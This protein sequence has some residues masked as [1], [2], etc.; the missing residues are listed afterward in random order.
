[1]FT[2]AEIILRMISK[3]IRQVI[4]KPSRRPGLLVIGDA[5]SDR[6]IWG[7]AKRLSPEAPVP[8]VD[9][10]EETGTPGG[11]ANVVQNLCKLNAT[12]SLCAVV[13]DDP[14]G[15]ELVEQL[16]DENIDTE[17]VITD[18]SRPTTVKTR[19]MAG[20]HQL[21]RLD[22]ESTSYISKEVEEKL[23][24]AVEKKIAAADMVLLSDYNKGL[25]SESFSQKVIALCNKKKKKVAIDPKGLNYEKYTGAWLIKPNK[26][27]LAE[28][29]NLEAIENTDALIAAARKVIAKTKSKYMV[30]TRSEEGLALVSKNTFN[31]FPVKATEVYDVTGAGDTVFASLG[32]FLSLGL[33]LKTACELANY[34]AA[35]AVRRVGSVAVTVDEILSFLPK[36]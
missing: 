16:K 33:D 36:K 27:E 10:K 21:L 17:A 2:L 12:V 8:V 25:L 11:A 18:E 3:E 4:T 23:F 24:S 30:V 22:K 29:A 5:M 31:N 9:V 13:G 15:N 26:R 1:M 35:I 28:A 32:Y 34:A 20:S 7:S 6:Y 14:A 19:V